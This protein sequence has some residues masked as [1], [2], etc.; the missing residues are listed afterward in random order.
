VK[1]NAASIPRSERIV[2]RASCG[3]GDAVGQCVRVAGPR[4][5]PLWDVEGVTSLTI[6]SQTPA[7]GVI[8]SK[9]SPTECFAQFHG[10]APKSLYAG[11]SAGQL[12]VVGTDGQPAAQGNTTYPPGDPHVF[13]QIGWATSDDELVV[14]PV[15]S[16]SPS[17][18]SEHDGLDTLTHK[19]AETHYVQNVFSGPNLTSSTVWTTPG[20]I[21]KIR[22]ST[23]TYSGSDLTGVV[24]EHYAID[25]V[26]VLQTLTKSLSYSGGNLVA[27]DVVRS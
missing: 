6:N 8:L 26:T 3:A 19:L 23:F 7:I 16:I 13:Q 18:L 22:E 2:R 17:L 10:P 9:S 4:V 20:M 24:V 15:S 25:G 11:L 12:Y 21:T 14:Q 5:G 1:A 27:V